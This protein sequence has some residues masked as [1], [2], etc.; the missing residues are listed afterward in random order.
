MHEPAP[1]P[2]RTIAEDIVEEPEP[3]DYHEAVPE[4]QELAEESY[5]REEAGDE[6]EFCVFNVRRPIA[7]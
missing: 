1:V 4:E 7:R 6:R 5:L 3:H 2:V